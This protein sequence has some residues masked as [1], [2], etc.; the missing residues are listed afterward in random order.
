M[1]WVKARPDYE[2]LFSI[3]DSLR[4]DSERR[5]WME[6][7]D[8]EGNN[9]DIKEYTGQMGTGVEILLTT[10]PKYLDNRGGVFTMMGN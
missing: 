9:F 2:P 8:V 10:S 4:L 5:D 6:R 7:R 3:L 1:V